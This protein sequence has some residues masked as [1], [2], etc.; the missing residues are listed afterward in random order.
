MD[1]TVFREPIEAASTLQYDYMR[2]YRCV[3][4]LESEKKLGLQSISA[5]WT[6]HVQ[7]LEILESMPTE[8]SILSKRYH[9]C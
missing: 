8:I 2:G 7:P 9:I 6:L 3:H 4:I 5:R 1:H